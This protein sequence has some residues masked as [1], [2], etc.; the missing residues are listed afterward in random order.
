M[1]SFYA[2]FFFNTKYKERHFFSDIAKAIGFSFI[3]NAKIDVPTKSLLFY[4]KTSIEKEYALF[5]EYKNIPVKI[6]SYT[7][8]HSGSNDHSVS[9]IVLEA[10]IKPTKMWIILH[11]ISFG[12]LIAKKEKMEKVSLEGNFNDRFD[13]YAR[14]DLQREVREIFTPDIMEKFNDISISLN[15]ELVDDKLYIFKM[16]DSEVG[17]EDIQNLFFVSEFVIDTLLEKLY[18]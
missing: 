6:F 15:F 12:E 11:M 16:L 4:E 3:N 10:T 1:D 17:K 2:L 13:M 8:N 5:G 9:N 14:E 7:Y 18:L